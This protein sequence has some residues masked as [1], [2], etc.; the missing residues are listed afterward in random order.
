MKIALVLEGGAMRGM[1]TAGVLDVF[2]DYDIKVD[3]IIGVS[4]GALFGINYLSKQRGR[5]IRYNKKYIKDKRY[6][7]LNSLL[8]T[9]N[10]INKDFAFN[11]IPFKLDKFDEDTFRKSK[12][13]FYVTITNVE[14]GKAEY[15]K[16][17]NTKRQMEY[18]RATAAMP[19]ISK[20]VNI[21][22][23]NYLDGAL[24][25]SIPI[26][27]CKELGYD[28]IIVILTKPLN[29]KKRKPISLFTKLKYRKYP[30]LVYAINNRYMMYNKTIEDLQKYEENNEIFIIRP[31]KKI[32]M[33]RIEKNTK[34]LDEMYNLGI[35]DAKSN[36][37]ELK[38]YLKKNK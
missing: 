4:A 37:K 1:Y 20:F 9:G 25:D 32:K 36:L 31:S 33:K 34:K 17:T 28:K 24:A 38:L 14:T 18:F 13:D 26:E 35:N 6:I 11:S 15:V 3:G 8:K 27:K 19:F 2:M 5:V 12:A 29:Y 30:N 10:I 16:I 21:N 7:S 22:N 23:Q